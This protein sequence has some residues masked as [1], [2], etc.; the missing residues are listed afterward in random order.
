MKK[1]RLLSAFLS[2]V[3]TMGILTAALPVTAATAAE[4]PLVPGIDEET[5]T[6]T[7]DYLTQ[8]YDTP[9]DKLATMT[10]YLEKGDMALYV[11]PVSGEVAY[12]NNKTGQIL[13]SNPYDVSQTS[14]ATSI[15]QELLSQIIIKYTDNASEL[16]MFSF[17]EACQ[18]GQ[19]NV[20]KI[21]NGV[22]VEYT[23]GREETRKLV[24]KQIKR[25]RFEE[26]I[27]ANIPEGGTKDRLLAFYTL[28]DPYDDSLTERAK[29]ELI[30]AFPICNQMAIYVFDPGATDR[31]LNMIEGWIKTYCPE[32]TYETLEED[33]TITDYV[34]TDK[35]PVL[36]RLSLE[37]KLDD[38][39][40]LDVRLPANGIRFDESAYQLTYISMLP[41]FGAG[42]AEWEGYTFIPDGSGT[43]VRFEDIGSKPLT[44]TGKIY[45]QDYAY[46]EVGGQN[47]EIMRLPVYGI[48][49]TANFNPPALTQDQIDSGFEYEKPEGKLS[50]GFVAIIEEGDSLAEIS[51]EHGGNLHKYNTVYTTFY[52][53]PKDTY[54]LAEAISVGS[55]A[56]YTVVSE[57]KYTGSYRIK[58]IMLTSEEN[59][60]AVGLKDYYEDSYV[61]MAK[62]Y[63]DY[64]IN[65]GILT[66]ITDPEDSI[67]LYI[68]SF[69][70]MNTIER[71]LSIPVEVLKPL[72]T[73]EDLKTMY[74]TLSEAGITNVNFKLT[75]YT[76]GGMND[77]SAYHVKFE[78]SVG[79]N[80][81]FTEFV[82]YAN[83]NSIGV[84]PDFDFANVGMFEMFDG[85][86]NKEHLIKTMDNRYTTKRYY[87]ST[88]QSFQR[89]YSLAISPSVYDYF[90]E[91]FNKEYSK[92]SPNGISVSTLGTDLNS[93]FDEDEPYNR[94]DSKAFTTEM[95]ANIEDA[96]SNVMIDGGNMYAVQ[97]ADHIIDVSLDSSRYSNASEA[98]PFMGLV[99]H[100]CVEF[101]GS[102]INMAGDTQYELLKAIE[103][104]AGLY[105]TLSMQNT[106]LLKEDVEFNKYYSVAFDI[107]QE[108][109]IDIYT[110]LN[111]ALADLQDK[112][113]VN[114]EFL[115]GERVPSAEEEEA[116]KI[117]AEEAAI[118]A[119]EE[120]K[121]A[122]EKADKA[123]KLADRL[124][125]LKAAAGEEASSTVKTVGGA[126]DAFNKEEEVD[127]N[128]YVYTKYTSDDG[129]IVK[130][131]YE[132]GTAF[133]LNY[134][135]FEITVED[136]GKTYTIAALDFVE[137]K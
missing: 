110:T 120:E 81:G 125:A 23:M 84:Y 91:N 97:Y 115:I 87:D 132:G 118:L 5:G 30:A 70:A 64:L 72:T 109:L 16:E 98:V 37:Y 67:P 130:V 21:K 134:N 33:H 49:E 26:L 108:E 8:T 43:L 104:G 102:A 103:N 20:K 77:T 63:R 94:E 85:V 45:G 122:A 69:G 61:G 40:T 101:A 126:S 51:T 22:R 38:D 39:G 105:F 123:Q 119:A 47:K 96:Y 11:E 95:L 128:A 32:Y 135:N 29:R 15:K 31:E 100:G 14:S 75:G 44:L 136:D 88:L 131:T 114:H 74:T 89:G 52:P 80:D 83:E 78:K 2:V 50:T 53:R 6:P 59:A 9:E 133:I 60:D 42:A 129:R 62:A 111:D 71:I 7:I 112:Q 79:G 18:R 36:F 48:V 107:W 12:V 92:L 46:Q 106:S 17:V 93:D 34:G 41:W 82:E 73:F 56:T 28:Q 90:F 86:S 121:I 4:E 54:N 76:N 13:F 3:M 66:E 116:D 137:V 58:Y 57:R 117:A 1:F 35:A 25:E 10:K 124:A 27:L 127:P 68:E 65:E 19:I 55:N 24:P 99:L 113:I